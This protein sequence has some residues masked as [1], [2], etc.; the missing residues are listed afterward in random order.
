MK[1]GSKTTKFHKKMN[2]GKVEIKVHK[3]ILKMKKKGIRSRITFL[4]TIKACQKG[5]VYRADGNT[6]FSSVERNTGG[7]AVSVEMA[8]A[9]EGLLW[10]ASRRKSWGFSNPLP[11]GEP[12]TYSWGAMSARG[13]AP[14]N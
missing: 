12:G 4:Q 13:S 1:L 5:H 8:S 14:W 6:M 10:R 9:G 2:N 3:N 11:R 7:G